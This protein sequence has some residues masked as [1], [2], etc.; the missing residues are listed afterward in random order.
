LS[1]ERAVVSFLEDATLTREEVDRFV[2]PAHPSWA[3]FDEELGYVPHPS[4]VPD[5]IDG[6]ISTYRY[7]TFGERLT[8][9]YA[10]RPCRINTYGDSMTQCHQVS[11]GETWQEQ[12]AAHFGE[13][14]RNFGVGGYGVYQAYRRLLR[15]EA[16]SCSAP[17]VVL[18][19]FLDDH[20]RSLD[21]YRLLRLGKWWRDYDRSLRT[22][23]FHANPWQHVR[24]DPA[25]G[26]LDER[27]NVCPTAQSLFNLCDRDFV[28]ETFRD[29]LV[30]KLLV[31]FA[32]SDFEFLREHEA[33]AATLGVS[34]DLSNAECGRLTAQRLYDACAF[35][36]SLLLLEKLRHLL[37]EQGKKLLVLLSYG[38]RTVAAVCQGAERPDADFVEALDKSRIPYADGL[39]S[40]QL[41]YQAFAVDGD[42]YVNRYYNGHY[43]PVG[44]HFFAFAVKDAIRNWL[45]PG[46]PAYEGGEPSFATQAGRLA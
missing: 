42:T 10:D 35:R 5:G 21:A 12:L 15:T 36:S 2:D 23:M 31:G 7:G 32:T 46:P 33:L 25:S 6:A 40:H 9:N 41:D 34:L 29:D 24:I 38:E 8:I 22:S 18:N 26:Q 14:I 20:Y 17:F 43:T 1:F 39:K 44:N 37:D 19:I 4:T 16:K 28:V 45:V 13:P 30:V 27:P 11:D 3:A